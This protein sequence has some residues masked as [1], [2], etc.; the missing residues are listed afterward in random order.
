MNQGSY[1]DFEMD[2]GLANKIGATLVMGKKDSLSMLSNDPGIKSIIKARVASEIGRSKIS[3]EAKE[4]LENGERG[5][6]SNSIFA[7]LTGINILRSDEHPRDASDLRRCRLLLE[8]VPE[9][10]HK[11]SMM[12]DV[13]PE[14]SA[15]ASDWNAICAIMDEETPSWREGI[16][17]ASLADKRIKE[18]SDKAESLNSKGI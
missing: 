1:K 16:G 9:F 2:S 15:I 17:R 5:L 14:W 18:L 4:W 7:R 11:I 3:D 10:G 8:A 13:S 12:K 6:S